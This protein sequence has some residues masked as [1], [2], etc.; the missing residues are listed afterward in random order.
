MASKLEYYSRMAEDTS[1][2]LTQSREQW[3]AFLQTAGRVSKYAYG[4]QLM[5]FAQRPEATACAEYD[6][7]NNTM[8]RYVRRGSKGIALIDNSGDY[9]RLRY[10]FDVADTGARRNSRPVNLW[11][12]REEYERPVQEAL[13]AV[14][15]VSARDPLDVQ[16]ENI[17]NWL[18]ID[19][20]MEHEDELADIVADSFLE[21][22]DED[23][24]RMSFLNAATVSI[25]YEILSRC[26]ENPDDYFEPDE[27]TPVFDYNTRKAT[28]ALGTAVSEVSGQVFREIEVTIRNYERS[29]RMERSHDHGTDLHTERGLP[30]SQPHPQG[31]QQGTPGQVRTDAPG[32]STGASPNPVQRPVPDGAVVP[33]SPG[34]RR[35]SAPKGRAVDAGTAGEE[36]RPGQADAANGLGAAHEQPEGAGRGDRAGGAGVQLN[37]FEQEPAQYEQMTLLF[38]SETKQIE[39]IDHEAESDKPSAFV[40]SDSEISR[41]LQTGSGFADGKLRI[42]ALYAHEGNPKARA[43]FLKKEYGI[44]GQSWDFSDGSRGLVDYR[45]KGLFI[46]SYGH[47]TELR[48][49]WTEVEKHIDTLVQAGRYLSPEEQA[50]YAQMEQDFAGYG[51]VPMP[52]AQHAFPTVP[53]AVPKEPTPEEPGFVKPMPEEDD[54]SDIDP[55]WVRERLAEHGIENGVVVDPEKLEQ[56]PFIQQVEADVERI[57]AE[58]AAEE[59]TPVTPED[60][61]EDRFHVIEVDWYPGR[62]AYSIW[63]DQTDSY[64]VD[65]EGLTVDFVSR[66]QAEEYRNELV[67]S[68]QR[69]ATLSPLDR[70]KE[71]IDEYCLEEFSEGADFTDLTTIGVA[72]TTLTDDE[73]PIQ[74]Y[75]DLVG[76]KLERYLGETLIDVRQY[77]SLEALIAGELEDLSFNDLTYASD[78]QIAAVLAQE[79]EPADTSLAEQAEQF[80]MEQQ[81]YRNQVLSGLTTDHQRIVAAMETAGFPF[82]PTETD[83]IYF[84]DLDD[85]PI[86][87]DSWDAVYEFIDS[88]ELKDTPGLREQV[89]AVLHPETVFPY[90]VGDTVYLEDGKPFVIDSIG[91]SDVHLLDPS[92]RFP[93]LRAESRENFLRLMERCPQ[94]QQAEPSPT[95]HPTVTEEPV[96]F[97]PG[98]QNGLPF[99]VEIRTLHFGEPE[100]DESKQT[101]PAQE[102]APAQET[103]AEP[104]VEPELTP[105]ETIDRN[106]IS[107]QIGGEWRTFPDREAAEE[108]LYADYKEQTHRNAQNF[109]ITDEA[110]GEGGPKAKYQANVAAIRLLQHLETEG[111]QASPEQQEVLSRYVGWGA[112]SDAFDP[113]KDSWAQEY[114]ELKSLLTEEEYAA[115]RA[116]TLNAHYTSPTVIKAIYEAVGNMGFQTGNI[117]EPSMGVGNF[118]GLLP[119]AMQG[120]KLYGV[121]LDSITGRI[122]RQLYPHADIKV[123][124]FETTDRRDFYDLAVGNV[125]FGDYKVNDRAYNKLGFSIHNYFFAKALDQVRP[126]GVVAF[127]TSRY[128]MDAKSPE[129]RKYLAQR[130]ELLGAIRLP[131]NAFRAN[132]GTDVVSDILFLQKRETPIDIEPDW[133]HLGQTPEGFAINSHFVDH[134]EMVLGELTSQSTQYG[135]DECTVAPLPGADLAEQ[136]HEAVSHIHGQYQAAVL[137]A[138]EVDVTD[139]P[140]PIPADPNVKNFSYTVVDGEVYFRENSVMRPVELNDKTKG[141][142]TGLVLL[143]Q[144]V[145]ELIE[146]QMEDYPE[147]DIAAKQRELNIAYDSFTAQY[148]I[149]NSRGNAQAFADDSSYYLLCSLEN[150]DE[151]GKFV[152]KA[153]M[154]TKR[155]IRPERKVTSVDTPS[156]ALAVSIGER[157]K[158]DLPFMSERL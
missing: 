37:P 108:A 88:A 147:E 32:F 46:R 6:L 122:A 24:R 128:T 136:L 8:R 84:G 20:W 49:R 148:G 118:F 112:L 23:S 41:V 5:I 10:V 72:F 28:N 86:T 33:P 53:V 2:G 98:E 87:F 113:G 119:E 79:A 3:T 67:E 39:A 137:E 59:E 97:Y 138:E 141:R 1:D 130:A 36:P 12:M 62:V 18:A 9:P 153:D 142:V 14:F 54:F 66:W 61:S 110:L 19:Y 40:I 74:A 75:V 123:A 115:A 17:A 134:P 92:L 156:E 31:D 81:D 42:A 80:E 25:K 44:G 52:S 107:V 117:L 106:P 26:V 21:G 63:D 73:I 93:V 155:T 114:Q 126:G 13:A 4:D 83:P 7:W 69:E 158:V 47:N 58:E 82:R 43:D 27:F 102:P 22:Y 71:L 77:D 16:V 99:D 96:A 35:D 111:L 85:Y 11:Q 151:N 76:F 131:N 116:S 132:A 30:D 124:G 103:A 140:Q 146:Y 150:L 157:G 120:S 139:G 94:E 65:K 104:V 101:A 143:R 133:V 149:I 89:Q 51:G 60:T 91:T 57:A 121:E 152:G 29:K 64:Y 48:L 127:V 109:H 45:S 100:R 78:E 90:N 50:R 34:D 105:E 154:F 145:N 95:K 125:P 56:S 144:I 15:E 70:A 38:P 68:A 55:E 129:V 135:K